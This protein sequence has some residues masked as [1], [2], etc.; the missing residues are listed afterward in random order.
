MERGKRVLIGCLLLLGGIVACGRQETSQPAAP[1]V[2]GWEKFEG[3]RVTLW[4]PHTY[5][6]G[7]LSGE[8]LEMIVDGL[9]KLG[10]DFEHSARVLERNPSAFIIF[11]V[12]SE[13][14]DSGALTSM[15]V[16]AERVPSALTTNRYIDIVAKKLSKRYHVMEQGLVPL[17]HYEAGRLVAEIE[18][19]GV[20]MKTVTYAI[21]DGYTMW[22]LNYGT[23]AGEFDRRFPVF[24]QSARS[25]TVKPQ[26]LWKRILAILW[27]KLV[28]V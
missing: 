1:P 28:R 9:R 21:K 15:N 12:D 13:V 26:P 18:V 23:G 4:L 3:S 22:I 5:E 24:E 19:Q 25:F 6:G 11:A 16:A 10:P 17:D 20:P 14:G 27:A 7:A 2:Q 8:N